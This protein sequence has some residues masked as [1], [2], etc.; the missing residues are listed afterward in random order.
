MNQTSTPLRVERAVTS[1]GSI[2]RC[3]FQQKLGRS[4]KSVQHR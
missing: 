2:H 3:E 4:T 1:D